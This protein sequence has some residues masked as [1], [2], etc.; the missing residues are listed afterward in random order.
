MKSPFASYLLAGMLITIS[1][2]SAAERSDVLKT[3]ANPSDVQVFLPKVPGEACIQAESESFVERLLVGR[4]QA[5]DG[6][7]H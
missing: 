7:F 6:A 3:Q 2:T 1:N 5:A 4:P